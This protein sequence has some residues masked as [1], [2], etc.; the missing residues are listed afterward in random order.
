[1]KSPMI[2]TALAALL[3]CSI[4]PFD[5]FAC[6]SGGCTLNADWASQGFKSNGGFSIDLRH[7]D[8][9]QT[10]LRT[11][12]GRVDRSAISFPADAEI[13]QETVNRNTTLTLDH[14]IN[15]AWG[16]SLQL[17]YINRYHTTIVD[18][19]TDIS[20][21]RSTSLGDMR[22]LGRYQGFSPEH[23]WGVQL[24]LK[25]PTGRTNLNFNGGPQ[26][27]EALTGACSPARVRPTC[28]SACTPSGR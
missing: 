7:D 21:S 28:C 23:N 16:A 18:G 22:L 14:G 15:A 3:A 12:T 20:T 4:F 1:M 13:Q 10:D 6:S 17:P 27:G 19:N 26:V 2:Q 9:S 11:G 25:L 24:G 8:F 5:A